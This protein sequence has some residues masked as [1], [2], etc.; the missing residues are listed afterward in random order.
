MEYRA[1]NSNIYIEEQGECEVRLLQSKNKIKLSE[2]ALDGYEIVS[3]INCSFF[4][5]QYVLGRNQGNLY[6]AT[7][8]DTEVYCDV[9]IKDDFYASGKMNSWDYTKDV[10]CGFSPA[11]IIVTAEV[12]V[13]MK[14]DFYNG[15]NSVNP[16]T[17]LFRANEKWHQCVVQGRSS[18]SKGMTAIEIREFLKSKY[19][20]EELYILDGGG[21][22][23]MIKNGKMVFTPSDGHERP[24]FNAIAFVRKKEKTMNKFSLEWWLKALEEKVWEK[25]VYKLGGIGRYDGPKGERTFDCVGIF[26]SL[27]WDYPAHPENYNNTYPD[28]NV[29]G[30]MARCTNVVPF[31]ATKL[32][33]GMV[34]FINKEHIG[35]VGDPKYFKDGIGQEDIIYECTPAFQN[36]VLRSSL[37]DRSKKMWT[38]MGYPDFV[39]FPENYFDDYCEDKI[40]QLTLELQ[41][42][43]ALAKSLGEQ[44]VEYAKKVQD[45]E[46]E[47]LKLENEIS[48][49][50]GIIE[51][52]INL[53]RS[54]NN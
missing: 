53:C 41:E 16:Q 20:V 11:S 5:N 9:V 44:I 34:V 54:T 49:L 51:G 17:C 45:K 1:Y 26:K 27:I 22:T 46:V 39:E 47:N 50:N 30:M 23:E 40:E 15:L 3:I 37:K 36:K 10:K 18:Q 35:M 28:V 8:N 7:H 12:D 48:R 33:A 19:K 21:S 24:M 42:S 29:G 25:N 52:V 4:T 13:T 31:D 6:Q 43:K 14:S 38:H 2:F 32:K